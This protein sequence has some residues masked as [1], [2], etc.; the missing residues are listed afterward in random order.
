MSTLPELQRRFARSV[1]TSGTAGD[2][3]L[4]IYRN[5]IRANYRNALRATFPVVCALTGVPFFHA[6]VDAFVHAHPSR[7][8]D[9]N[10][11]GG[12]FGAFLASYP[13]ARD[14]PYLPDVARLE[15]AID[16]AHRAADSEATPQDLVAALGNVPPDRLA[17]LQLVPD[18]SCRLLRSI[19]PV[20]RIWQVHQAD[21]AGEPRVD[22]DA[23]PECLLVRREAGSVAVERVA[24]AEFAWLEALQ[25]GADLS[26]ALDAALSADPAFSLESV[27]HARIADRTLASVRAH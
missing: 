8:G 10:V 9:L 22:F 27:L 6:A 26:T 16:D 24:A 13:H 25:T 3:R 20:L 18:P 12:G 15:W 1:G 17:Q 5:T 7:G 4:D 21:F 14:L 19:H 2:A 11:Y 23:P